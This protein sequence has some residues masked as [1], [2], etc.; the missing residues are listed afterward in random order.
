MSRPANRFE[1]RSRLGALVLA[2]LFLAVAA[3]GTPPAGEADRAWAA[4]EELRAA[5]QPAG[6]DS[7]G[8]MAWWERSRAELERQGTAFL[9]AFPDDPRRWAVAVNLYDAL[10]GQSFVSPS[11]PW[12]SRLRAM[13]TA[14]VD[15]AGVPADI[16]EKA[17]LLLIDDDLARAGETPSAT[18]LR[19]LQ[20]R[21]D[22]H[23]ERF[24][25]S[26]WTALCQVRCLERLADVAPA[27]VA[28]V[29]D[30][31]AASP[32]AALREVAATRRFLD[33]LRSEPF[34]LRFTALDGRAVDFSQLRGKVVLLDFWATWCKPCVAEL[35]VLQELYRRH[36][37]EGFE[38]VGVSLDRKGTGA[39]L[40][41]FVREHALPWPQHF[42]LNEH[43]RNV[44][45]V[46]FGITAI[47]STFL[48]DRSGR[49]VR[50][51]LRGTEL[52]AE[53]R[54]LLGP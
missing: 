10:G 35:P 8:K 22:A 20:A 45:A 25:A 24:G 48:F 21:L 7:A 28:A 42:E 44:L 5:P 16:Q 3:R 39:K 46:Q 51:Q 6:L 40:S 9:E 31:L 26:A 36:H 23:V 43:G 17:S 30:R 4:F 41:D 52:E 15:A 50:S 18:Q 13:M 49:L 2:L 53:V 14:A 54:R 33:R 32:H 38:I 27:E 1:A 47:P 11:S 37:A 12:P 34:E 29:V 19:A